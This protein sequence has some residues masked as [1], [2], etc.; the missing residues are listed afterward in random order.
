MSTLE[1]QKEIAGMPEISIKAEPVFH[2]S[3]FKVTNSLV[4]SAVVMIAFVYIAFR[5]FNEIKSPRKTGFFYVINVL[6]RTLYDLFGSIMGRNINFF[7][8]LL[9]AFF[10]YILLQNWFGL[11][12]G[13]GSIMV[14]VT[15]G[16][17]VL[18]I[19]LFRGNNAD[20]NATLALAIISVVL[21]QVYGVKFL[22]FK[23]H[24]QKYVN[25]SNP[26][27]FFLGF[28][29]ILSEISR[30]LSFAFR[31]FGN[32]FAGEVLMTIVAFL[33]PVLASFPFLILEIFVGMVQALVFSLLTSV[34]MSLAVAK[35]HG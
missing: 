34:F 5:Y 29:E 33:V 13:V 22:G 4:L 6:L 21:M 1:T 2:I 35:H 15:E 11:L 19:P 14:A 32:I 31:L 17:H 16:V 9:S 28:L 3:S 27:N 20:I 18:H 10:V 7:F 12:P 30:V 23:A 8:P 25:L 26:I 24:I